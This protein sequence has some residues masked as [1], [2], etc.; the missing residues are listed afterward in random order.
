MD[1]LSRLLFLHPMRTALDA[2]CHLRAP[3][4]M[5][6]ET[7]SP[8]VAPY[9]L[10]VEGN[11]WMDMSG[12]DPQSLQVG[13]VLL[14]PRGNAH[15]LYTSSAEKALPA[16]Q[17]SAPCVV[18][19]LD[20]AGDGPLTDI[21]CGQFHFDCMTA[22]TLMSAL[23]EVVLLRTAGNPDFAGLQTLAMM[24]RDETGQTKPGA[25]AVVSHLASTLF[26]LLIRAWLA[27]HHS[28]PG[29]FALLAEPRLK[30]ALQV[31][32]DAPE[33]NW[34]VNAL[35]QSCHMSRATFARLFHHVAGA[36]PGDILLRTRMAQA[37]YFLLHDNRTV[38]E[39][40]EAVGYQSE[41]AFNRAFKRCNGMG[42]GQYRNHE[43]AK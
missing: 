9:H 29:L 18:P 27:Q 15:T 43:Q 41:A 21:L 3:W 36:T 7:M 42:P 13:D 38:G 26:S 8:G 23:P 39:I 30:T 33:K 16:S 40:G 12:H 2:R 25:Y 20:N 34:S 6:N 22:N 35:A 1:T 32:L 19:L 4:H 11:C 10:V 28:V 24:L 37:A 31:M 5:V 17:C 14:F